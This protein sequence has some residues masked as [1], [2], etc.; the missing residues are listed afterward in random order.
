[1]GSRLLILEDV[2]GSCWGDGG[3]CVDSGVLRSHELRLVGAYARLHSA[4]WGWRS[5]QLPEC[6]TREV[7]AVSVWR[8]LAEQPSATAVLRDS[9]RRGAVGRAAAELSVAILQ[10]WRLCEGRREDDAG[11]LA[12]SCVLHGDP[13]S[14]NALDLVAGGR[15]PQPGASVCL[16]DFER[17]ALGH[18]AWD[19]ALLVARL[20]HAHWS[21][22]PTL[23]VGAV[24]EAYA[25]ELQA[26]GVVEY[27]AEAC[28][29]DV[30]VTL[31]MVC[32]GFVSEVAS[33]E[34]WRDAG[35]EG[36][37]AAAASAL[38][39]ALRGPHE[40][41]LLSC[42]PADVV[43]TYRLGLQSDGAAAP[44]VDFDIEF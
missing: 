19:L 38:D 10:H 27:A 20:W 23:V 37:Q 1:M 8:R 44:P 28:A 41:A 5:N 40:E 16:L 13:H 42:L 14:Q 15:T 35:G 4:T 30:S 11:A 18:P 6:L 22:E 25:C 34:W 29:A 26:S 36:H 9:V 21:R 33:A 3:W 7:P 12:P 39:A 2:G 24:A 43:E 17:A 32:A 31:L